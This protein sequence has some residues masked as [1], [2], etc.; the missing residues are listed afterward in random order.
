MITSVPASTL[1]GCGSK[2]YDEA[3][4]NMLVQF[5]LDQ[6]RNPTSKSTANIMV[7]SLGRPII[8]TVLVAICLPPSS[9]AFAQSPAGVYRGEWRSGS[10]GHRGPMRAVVQPTSDGNYQARFSG[11]FALIIP[12]TYKVSLHPS[13]DLNGNTFLTAEKPLGPILGSY[14]MTAVADSSGLNG[15]FQAAGDNGSIRMN[16]VR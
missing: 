13:V 9:Q 5:N 7:T 4:T 6:T 10:N 16:R 3:L 11:R 15:N 12:F 1:T 8:L 14:R 2:W